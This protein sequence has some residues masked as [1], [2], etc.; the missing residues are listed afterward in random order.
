MQRGSSA[1]F[2]S[3]IF[4]SIYHASLLRRL[5]LS[6]LSGIEGK[7]SR[8][9]DGYADDPRN[10][11]RVQGQYP[12]VSMCNSYWRTWSLDLDLDLESGR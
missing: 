9:S 12:N 11:E 7:R 6:S 10:G 2:F 5:Y 1:L 3:L 8:G 4:F